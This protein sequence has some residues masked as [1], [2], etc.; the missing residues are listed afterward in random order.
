MLYYLKNRLKNKTPNILKEMHKRRK[1]VF[2]NELKWPLKD[3]D[4]MEIDEFDT[5]ESEYVVKLDREYGVI[6]GYRILQTSEPYLISEVFS[7]DIIDQNNLPKSKTICEIT[8]FFHCSS[9]G[10]KESLSQKRKNLLEMFISVLEFGVANNVNQFLIDTDTR[11]EALLKKCGW[12]LQRL[13]ME[14]KFGE[15][16][17]VIGFLDCNPDLLATVRKNANIHYPVL[18]S[19]LDGNTLLDLKWSYFAGPNI[20]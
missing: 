3:Y 1:E 7:S 19:H 4:G 6:G 15:F 9:S 8:R 16:Q 10:K 5:P 12:P 13:S 18:M 14:R 2:I 11:I 17:Y 20:Y